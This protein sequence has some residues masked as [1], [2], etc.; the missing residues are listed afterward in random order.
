MEAKQ[1]IEKIL[2]DARAEAEKIKK[3]ADEKE[4]AEQEKF[5]EQLDEHKKQTNAL[6]DKLGREILQ[7]NTSP[8]KAK[9][10]TKSSN[11]HVNNC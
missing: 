5:N 7:K 10:S 8:K 6:A 1:V 9:F 11:R 2:A 4:A 3:Q